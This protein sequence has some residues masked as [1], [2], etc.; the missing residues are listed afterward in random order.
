MGD[1]KRRKT[2]KNDDF[3][4]PRTGKGKDADVKKGRAKRKIKPCLSIMVI[5]TSIKK[6]I[7]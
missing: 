5:I 2:D 6:Y 1:V 3:D 4:R 7:F